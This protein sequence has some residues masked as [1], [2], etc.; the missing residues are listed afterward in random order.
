V[1]ENNRAFCYIFVD[2]LH[3]IDLKTLRER[4]RQI[5]Q[6]QGGRSVGTSSQSGRSS[7]SSYSRY[8]SL[9]SGTYRLARSLASCTHAENISR[10]AVCGRSERSAR[11][12]TPRDRSGPRSVQRA[13]SPVIRDNFQL[14]AG[15][16]RTR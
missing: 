15:Y 13:R 9:W 1:N 11:H 10:D 2:C 5:G 7:S 14:A 16:H 6:A 8:K 3:A 12:S 4:S